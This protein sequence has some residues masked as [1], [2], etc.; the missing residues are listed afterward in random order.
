[1]NIKILVTLC[2][3]T[4]VILAGGIIVVAEG[5]DFLSSVQM[6]IGDH[7]TESERDDHESDDNK[8]NSTSTPQVA[9]APTPSPSNSGQTESTT[10]DTGSKTQPGTTQ[11]LVT[12][13][14]VIYDLQSFRNQHS[15]GDVFRC[16]RDMSTVFHQQHN[17][18][19]LQIIQPYKV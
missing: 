12:V 8:G 16:G 9:P 11:C 18:K 5:G 4:F 1:M 19:Y 14:G 7:E 13:D 2:L 17:Q 15:G 6:S 3:A 10:G